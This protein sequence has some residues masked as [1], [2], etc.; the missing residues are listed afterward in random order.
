MIREYTYN[1]QGKEL[2]VTIGKVAKQANG[3]CLVE[4]EDS[5]VSEISFEKTPVK[6]LEHIPLESCIQHY[7][8]IKW[9]GIKPYDYVHGWWCYKSDEHAN[10]ILRNYTIKIK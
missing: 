2:K 4:I 5:I 1:L 8:G 6:E 9:L 7:N 3:S 10:Y